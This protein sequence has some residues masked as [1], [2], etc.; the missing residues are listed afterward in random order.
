MILQAALI[1]LRAA[2]TAANESLHTYKVTRCDGTTYIVRAANVKEAWQRC[3][4]AWF[5]TSKA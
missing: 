4:D 3:D 1:T 5:I 2:Q